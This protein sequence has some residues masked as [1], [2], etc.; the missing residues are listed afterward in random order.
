MAGGVT[1]TAR[2]TFGRITCD[3]LDECEF[4]VGEDVRFLEH[5]PVG[6]GLVPGAGG[7]YT[8]GTAH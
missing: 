7:N 2:S 1:T 3:V 6:S 4:E 5:I 8:S